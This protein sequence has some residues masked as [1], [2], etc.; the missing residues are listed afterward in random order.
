MSVVLMEEVPP[1][2]GGR[3]AQVRDVRVAAK[4][5]DEARKAVGLPRP[6]CRPRRAAGVWRERTGTSG[7]CHESSRLSLRPVLLSTDRL[8]RLR[9]EPGDAADAHDR[10]GAR[11]GAHRGTDLPPYGGQV[12]Y[13]ASRWAAA[14]SSWLMGLP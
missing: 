2:P 3:A 12:D 1:H 11:A 5:G 4:G 6:S 9:V 7:G 14:S 10:S 8:R 13:A